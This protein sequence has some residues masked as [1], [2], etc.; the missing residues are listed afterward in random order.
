MASS[1][2]RIA[3]GRRL[4]W[5]RPGSHVGYEKMPTTV[6]AP[7]S[8]PVRRAGSSERRSDRLVQDAIDVLHTWIGE[9]FPEHDAA[10]AVHLIFNRRKVLG[11][12][13]VQV[14]ALR[15]VVPEQTVGGLA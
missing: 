5:R 1:T 8:D 12:V 13:K 7:E 2:R 10:A 3:R 11:S 14:S 9:S 15:E 4:R 6:L